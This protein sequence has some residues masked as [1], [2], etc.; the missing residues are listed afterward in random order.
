MYAEYLTFGAWSVDEAS[1]GREALAKAIASRPDVIVTDSRLPGING[2]DLC[3]ILKRDAT[4]RAIPIVMVTGDAFAADLQRAQSAGVD[5]ILVKPCL[6]ETLAGEIQRLLAQS[7][8][9]RT[10]ALTS[11]TPGTP[12]AKS[13]PLSPP[14]R[15]HRVALSRAHQRHDTTTPPLPPPVLICPGCDQALVY[16]R[17]HVGG[18]SA[19]NAEQWDYFECPHGCGTFQYRVRTRKL[20]RVQ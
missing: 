11:R 2:F 9:H 5:A 12:P 6:P 20:R 7:Q 8:E 18:V 17:S 4:T 3:S 16:M 1:D 15:T 14:H 19:H 10:R 13:D